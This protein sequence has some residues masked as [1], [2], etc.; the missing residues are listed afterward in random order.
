MSEALA[1]QYLCR[2]EEIPDGQGLGF[3]FG[4]GE[5]RTLI[6]VVRQGKRVY[7]YRNSC[8]HIGTPLDMIP[9]RFMT[10]DKRHILCMTH[11][12]RFR[13]YDGY[14]FTGPCQGQ[15]LARLPLALKDGQV[16]LEGPAGEA[17]AP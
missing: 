1:P 14:C 5:G 11:G 2:L 10:H 15:S 17:R 16:F 12:A 3:A 13:V 7:G 8:P 4:E 6:F 9:D